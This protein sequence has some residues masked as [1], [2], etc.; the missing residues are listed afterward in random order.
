[1]A[2]KNK[3]IQM[4]AAIKTIYSYYAKE[5]DVEMLVNTWNVLLR[6]YPDN[7][8]E[9]AFYKCLQT[10]KM[11]PTPAD[12]IEQIK[13]M[14]EANEPTEEEL[15]NSF[16]M[17]LHNTESELHY[18]NFPYF[19]E[20]P[21]HARQRITKIWENLPEKVKQYIG[22]KGELMRIARTYTD[23]ELKFERNRFFKTMP[24]IQKRIEYKEMRMALDSGNKMMLEGE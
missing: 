23:E 16:T 22:S 1:M 14:Q 11:P 21:D 8:V 15:W 3:I 6:D 7:A 4:I 24:T 12:V 17:A 20:T 10:C 19:G 5:T 13:S 2:T 18:I 9:V